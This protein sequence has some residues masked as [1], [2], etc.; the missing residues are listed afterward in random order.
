MI[1]KKVSWICPTYRR[2]EL[3]PDVLDAFFSQDWDG[4]KELV[5]LNDEVD[6]VLKCDHPDVIC[7]NWP[8]RLN[9]IG[10]KYNLAGRNC[11]GD[12]LQPTD[13]DDWYGPTRMSDAATGVVGGFFKASTML[14]DTDPVEQ[15]Y[16]R[17]HCN[18]AFTPYAL[19]GAGA[20][21]MGIGINADMRLI[22]CIDLQMSRWGLKCKPLKSANYLYRKFTWKH[23]WTTG[24]THASD[25]EIPR[26]RIDL[27][28]AGKNRWNG[29]KPVD[30]G[31]SVHHVDRTLG[32]TD[33]PLFW[34]GIERKVQDG[35][36]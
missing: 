33:F 34:D 20:H 28:P 35:I 29:L 24:N 9:S 15:V 18:Y 10:G 3:L 23:H 22:N 4:E 36:D 32:K 1:I 31:R 13:D 14:I 12:L 30:H 21:A 16:G 8:W 25:D 17:M 2:T 11:S 7:V 26:G 19:I 6:Q 5:I 27:V